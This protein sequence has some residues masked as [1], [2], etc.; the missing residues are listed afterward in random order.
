MFSYCL[1]WMIYVVFRFLIIFFSFS[2]MPAYHVYAMS[3]F[4]RN[5]LLYATN[6][7][8]FVNLVCSIFVHSGN[9]YALMISFVDN[10]ILAIVMHNI[11]KNYL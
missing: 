11:I 4:C 2:F 6:H 10:L 3:R 8:L 9:T 1:F 7:I 5:F